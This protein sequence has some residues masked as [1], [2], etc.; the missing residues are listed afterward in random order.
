MTTEQP[1]PN[2]PYPF[3]PSDWTTITSLFK[4][5]E[6][7]SIPPGGFMVWLQNWN[8]LD[9]AIWDAYTFLKRRAYTDT[10]DTEAERVYQ[11]YVEQLY[12]TY[13]GL[14][15]TL[16][17]R[18]LALQPTAPSL[19]YERLWRVWRNQ[20][21]LF[22]PDSLPIQAEISRLEGR[23]REIMRRYEN[24]STLMTSAPKS[25]RTIVQ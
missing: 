15:Q 18:A 4:A 16:Y 12:S 22:H 3:D 5:L 8:Q 11:A 14:T 1:E 17:R 7:M 20:T 19:D 25:P 13:L 23:Y 24:R 21:T 6:E 9:I 2:A 10:R